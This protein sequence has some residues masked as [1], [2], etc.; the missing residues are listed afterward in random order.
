M[1]MR[2]MGIREMAMAVTQPEMD[3]A[4][5]VRLTRRIIRPVRMLMVEV[6]AMAMRM[7][8]PRVLMLV[9]VTLGQVKP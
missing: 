6:M 4:M 1:A 7:S 2:M 9:L 5:R 8:E 3:V